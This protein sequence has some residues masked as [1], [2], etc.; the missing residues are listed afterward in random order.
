MADP[1][2]AEGGGPTPTAAEVIAAAMHSGDRDCEVCRNDAE[3]NVAALLAQVP[4]GADLVIRQDG[5]LA[6]LELHEKRAFAFRGTEPVP[7]LPPGAC[8]SRPQWADMSALQPAGVLGPCGDGRPVPCGSSAD[9]PPR[10]GEDAAGAP[11]VDSAALDGEAL[12]DLFEADWLG[13]HAGDCKESLDTGQGCRDNHYMRT[14]EPQLPE[15]SSYR[16]NL[17]TVA[18]SI[19]QG[20]QTLEDL[21]ARADDDHYSNVAH[22]LGEA[23]TDMWALIDWIKE[24]RPQR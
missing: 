10:L 22:A 4:S 16:G 5:R 18:Q 7:H 17:R 21:S 20:I 24:G 14:D 23:D 13:V 6:A 1:I 15:D 9:G 2:R 3:E 19:L 11:L 8:V 12:S